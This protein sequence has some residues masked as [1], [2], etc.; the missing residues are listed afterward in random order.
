LPPGRA[1]GVRAGLNAGAS[2]NG[3][4]AAIADGGTSTRLRDTGRPCVIVAPG[5]A[6]TAPGTRKLENRV[7]A[8]RR[9][10]AWFTPNGRL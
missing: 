3:G 8:S 7:G 10:S 6:V 5:T 4:A 9:K 2:A 1:A